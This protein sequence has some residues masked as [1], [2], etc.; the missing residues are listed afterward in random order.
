MHT[1]KIFH[2]VTDHF[3]SSAGWVVI[4][5]LALGSWKIFISSAPNIVHYEKH[6]I[7]VSQHLATYLLQSEWTGSDNTF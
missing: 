6:V 5:V 4:P 1:K 3:E 7:Q 2:A